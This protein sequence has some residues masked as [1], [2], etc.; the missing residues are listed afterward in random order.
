[1]PSSGGAEADRPG[2]WQAAAAARAGPGAGCSGAEADAAL[3]Q[4]VAEAIRQIEQD[5]DEAEGRAATIAADRKLLAELEAV[6]G[7]LAE[8]TDWKRTDADYGDAF[9]N[10]GLD[11]DADDPGRGRAWIAAR[12][13]PVELA[14]FLD[15]WAYI[16]GQTR[17][18]RAGPSS[19]SWQ[20]P[21]PRRH[22][23]LARRPPHPAS[24]RKVP[25][26]SRP[27]PSSPG[28][29]R[30]WTTSRPRACNCWPGC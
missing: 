26:R 27:C 2:P 6:R 8:H 4:R 30:R 7:A 15:D 3:R 23:P 25:R 18:R 24:G 13:A 11:L 21:A 16:R 20:R 17:G 10:A 12:T 22:G 9:R 19:G 14:S 1:M 5:R 28:M 29:T